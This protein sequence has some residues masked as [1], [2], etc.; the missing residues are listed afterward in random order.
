MPIKRF[1]NG[2]WLRVHRLVGLAVFWKSV[3]PQ[4]QPMKRYGIHLQ[5][6]KWRMEFVLA[7]QL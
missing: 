1:N 2:F 5:I 7:N 3:E 6:F 4:L